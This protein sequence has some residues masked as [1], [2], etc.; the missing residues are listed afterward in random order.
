MVE[1]RLRVDDAAATARAV[2][3]ERDELAGAR[4]SRDRES[5]RVVPADTLDDARAIGSRGDDRGAP[6]ARR[7]DDGKRL[8]RQDMSV[9]PQLDQ[10]H[11]AIEVGWGRCIRPT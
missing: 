7:V 4:L 9:S 11:G 8:A 1:L 6:A 3:A 10:R 5:G 2:L